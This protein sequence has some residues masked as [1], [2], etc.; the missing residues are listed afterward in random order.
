MLLEYLD[1]LRNQYEESDDLLDVCIFVLG[2]LLD[3]SKINDFEYL[4][5]FSYFISDLVHK[6]I[7]QRII[8]DDG[9]NVRYMSKQNVH[10]HITGKII[11][12]IVSY[13]KEFMPVEY[14]LYFAKKY[15]KR[16]IDV[17]ES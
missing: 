11:K 1:Q 5:T 14:K 16:V 12:M 10:Q 8:I 2:K 4:I 3:Q 9:N 7:A 13:A 6:T 15:I 17:Q